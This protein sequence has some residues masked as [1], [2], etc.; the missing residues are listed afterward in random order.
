[1][2]TLA[3]LPDLDLQLL[4]FKTFGK[5]F[6]KK[7]KVSPDAFVQMALQ[8]AYFRDHG[9]QFALTYESSMTRL[10]R[11]ATSVV[12]LRS[13]SGPHAHCALSEGRT[14]T[15]RP[16]SMESVKFV[17]AMEDPSVT[18]EERRKLLHEYVS[19][20]GAVC[21]KGA[22][23]LIDVLFRPLLSSASS[24]FVVLH[25]LLFV[26]VFVFVFFL[27]FFFLLL[28]F[29]FSF[30]F[31]FFFFSFSFSFSFSSSLSQGCHHSR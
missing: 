25:S 1:M 22:V 24:S 3:T 29:S 17:R 10:F 13:C 26:F 15:V 30:S 8:L 5:G 18:N 2:L 20:N 6:I 16:V 23:L 27:L 21:I 11:Y 4:P 7:C 31:S 28:L 9:N 14:E 19:V 12:R